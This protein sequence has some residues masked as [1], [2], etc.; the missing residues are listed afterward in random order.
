MNVVAI[1]QENKTLVMMV[2]ERDHVEPFDVGKLPPGGGIVVGDGNC[3]KPSNGKSKSQFMTQAELDDLTAKLR[4]NDYQP[5]TVANKLASTVQQQSIYGQD[6]AVIAL[7]EYAVAQVA[8]N[9]SF[10]SGHEVRASRGDLSHGERDK[11]T[12]DFLTIQNSG[13]YESPGME[14]I[15]NIAW[16]TLDPEDYSMFNLQVRNPICTSPNKLAAIAV[17]VYDP[18]T[19]QLREYNGKPWGTGF[20]VRRVIGLNGV[21]RGTGKEAPGNP[22]RAVLRK[23]GRAHGDKIDRNARAHLDYL[24]RD[25]ILAFRSYGPIRPVSTEA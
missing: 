17:A 11:V 2:N 7:N 19:G 6:D 12:G 4:A 13:G 3:W 20:I 16:V 8:R 1:D 22:M 9:G 21:M 10:D 5:I 23:L 15:V 14:D 18:W 25:M 24:V